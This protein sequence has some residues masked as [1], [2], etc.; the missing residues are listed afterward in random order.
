M[1]RRPTQPNNI[2][3]LIIT[4]ENNFIENISFGAHIKNC[5]HSTILFTLEAGFR[6]TYS[7]KNLPNFRTANLNLFR[8]KMRDVC[9]IN[10]LFPG[11]AIDILQLLRHLDTKCVPRKATARHATIFIN[12]LRNSCSKRF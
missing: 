12:F 11:I 10:V 8:N 6:I 9:W 4:N 1:I 3:D 2:L 5:D 7:K